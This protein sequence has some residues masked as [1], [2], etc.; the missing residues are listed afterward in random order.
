MDKVGRYVFDAESFHCDLSH[1]LFMGHL[2]NHLLNA[3]DRHSA[4][5]GFG[6]PALAPLHMTWVLSRL[7]IEMEE[8]PLQYTQFAVETWIEDA[9]RL[10]TRRNF[11]ISDAATDRT[12]GYG[13]SIWAMIDTT[14]RQPQDITA[15][16]DGAIMQWTEPDKPCPIESP[17]RVSVSNSAQPAGTVNTKYSDIDVNGHVNSIKY[18]EHVLD[19]F[20]ARWHA[21]HTIRRIDVAYVAESRWGDSL[22]L[23]RATAADG[24]SNVSITRHRDGDE[25][26]TEVCRCRITFNDTSTNKH[27]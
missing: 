27:R 5:R 25:G 22:T 1:R 16:A 14:T 23:S 7:A 19:T 12:L 11:R 26:A 10:F 8:M 17:S 24:S 2:G 9:V 18:I 4:A 13:R 3:A 15:A 6:M 21:S 20:D